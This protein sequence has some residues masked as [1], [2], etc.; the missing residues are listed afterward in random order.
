LN[1]YFQVKDPHILFNTFVHCTQNIVLG[2]GADSERTLPPLRPVFANNVVF[3]DLGYY[4]ITVEDS[5]QDPLWEGNIMYGSPLGIT[6]PSGVKLADPTLSLGDD[7][8]WRPAM[9]SILIDSAVGD[10][11]LV[12]TDLDGQPRGVTKDIGADEYSDDPV[13]IRPLTPEDVGPSWWPPAQEL[14]RVIAV[15]AGHDSLT[16]AVGQALAGDVIELVT[17]GGEY[18]VSSSLLITIPLTVR[19]G[20]ELEV[21]P[22]IRNIDPDTGTR[23]V[24]EIQDG[25]R[26]TLRGLELDGMAGSATPA[27][28][29]IRT[30][31]DPMSKSY[32]LRVEDCYLH[33]VVL[34]EDGNFFRAYAGTY[35]DSVV[36]RDCLFRNSGKEGI[37]LKDEASGSGSYNVGY[38]E[39]TNSTL[40]LTRKEAVFLYAGD[41]VP[42]TPGPVVRINHCTF[43]SCAYEG[44]AVIA[45]S[46]VDDTVIR[47]CIFSNTAMDYPAATLYG[48][49]AS[50]DYSDLYLTGSVVTERSASVGNHMLAQDPMYADRLAGDFTLAELSPLRGQAEDG[51]SM[52][53]LRW[54]GETLMIPGTLVHV[55]PGTFRLFQNYPNPFNPATRIPFRLG[56]QGHVRLEVYNLLGDRVATLLDQT[57]RAGEHTYIWHPQDLGS[58]IYLGRLSINGDV[59]VIRMLY[60]K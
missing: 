58:G 47:N 28:Y 4:L 34:G 59:N 8:L 46:E 2:L 9:E 17:A 54:S 39:L 55:V 51:K 18:T 45:A 40:W 7:D 24:I 60:L 10:Y 27:K 22:V 29:L 21:R 43:D 35:A 26:V 48:I 53:D 32:T 49:Q 12:S 15:G 33:D 19:A 50:I 41:D 52:G 5:P 13:T 36:F 3:S 44:S 20:A 16:Y 23:T 31:D 37:R 56:H 6:Q 14:P 1:R 11:P 30:D 38:F 57:M 25:G 42:Y